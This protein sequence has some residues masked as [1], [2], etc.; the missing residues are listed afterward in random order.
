MTISCSKYYCD[1]CK[2]EIPDYWSIHEMRLDNKKVYDEKRRKYFDICERC[3]DE[4]YNRT[5][6][7]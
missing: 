7:K 4:I 5:I 1:L 6:R 3:F 2:T